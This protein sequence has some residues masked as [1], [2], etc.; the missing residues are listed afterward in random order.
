MS[1][2]LE[3][4]GSIVPTSR[5]DRVLWTGGLSLVTAWIVSSCALDIVEPGQDLRVV[6]SF[7]GRVVSGKDASAMTN[8]FRHRLVV[9]VG[10][11][12]V[13]I[14]TNGF[15]QVHRQITEFPPGQEVKINF[16]ITGTSGQELLRSSKMKPTTEETMLESFQALM[17]EKR[18]LTT[19]PT[20]LWRKR[21]YTDGNG[22]LQ[23]TPEYIGTIKVTLD[24]PRE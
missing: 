19:S 22:R 12:D 14:L 13:Y 2:G 8:D 6:G 5:R 1:R 17:D 7:E 20:R 16:E 3:A 23:W 24:K 4:E 15:Y 9:N 21:Y 10:E 18:D 11:R